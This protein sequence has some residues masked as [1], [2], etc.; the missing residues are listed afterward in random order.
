MQEF[1]LYHYVSR[2]RDVNSGYPKFLLDT[3]R[4][5]PD[6]NIVD[7]PWLAGGAVRRLLDGSRKHSDLDFFFRNEEELEVWR[8]LMRISSQ[9]G[10][11]K[12]IKDEDRAHNVTMTLVIDD[13]EVDVQLIKFYFPNARSIIQWFDYTICQCVAALD[14]DVNDSFELVLGDY[15]AY[16]I[17]R[18]RLVVNNMHHAVSSVRRLIKYANQ[19]YT[20]CG[21]TIAEI[22]RRVAEDSS[23]IN[24]DIISID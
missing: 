20:A 7:G 12:L 5:L 16:D 14:V 6:T 2:A 23:I 4:L 10:K 13:T 22:L 8:N 19:G 1:N 11:F 17:A 15:A 9:N 24:Q 18:R 3:L 21:G